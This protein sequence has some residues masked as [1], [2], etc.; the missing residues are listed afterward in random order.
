MK[1]PRSGS[2]ERVFVILEMSSFYYRA[3]E[4]A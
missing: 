2:L 1:K 3:S 4:A